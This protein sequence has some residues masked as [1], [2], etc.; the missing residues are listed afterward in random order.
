MSSVTVHCLHSFYG[1]MS[2][3]TVRTL[4]KHTDGQTKYL[5]DQKQHTCQIVTTT[6]IR[7]LSI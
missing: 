1:F 6:V 7:V 4:Y 2:K 5:F 3:V